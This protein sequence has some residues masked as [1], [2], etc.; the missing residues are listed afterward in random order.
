MSFLLDSDICSAHLR[1]PGA[2][3]HRF[4]QHSGRLWRRR[5]SRIQRVGSEP[6][7]HA[8]RNVPCFYFGLRSSIRASSEIRLDDSHTCST[9]KR[10]A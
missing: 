8:L 3:F 7:H 1:R 9:K 6:V 10:R 5:L 2:L 4:M